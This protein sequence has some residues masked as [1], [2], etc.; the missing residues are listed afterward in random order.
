MHTNT[1]FC[2]E[3]P[4]NKM[5]HFFFF[6][7]LAE[8]T[9][10]ITTSLRVT[11][12]RS[13][14]LTSFDIISFYIISYSQDL[15]YIMHRVRRQDHLTHS[16]AH[17]LKREWV[18]A[19]TSATVKKKNEAPCIIPCIICH[20]KPV[21]ARERCSTCYKAWD[22]ET[23]KREKA[24]EDLDFEAI[25][26]ATRSLAKQKKL[27]KIIHT[28]L[29]QV[30]DGVDVLAPADR[31]AFKALLKPYFDQLATGLVPEPEEEDEDGLDIPDYV[32]SPEADPWEDDALPT[33][34]L[35]KVENVQ[36]NPVPVKT[37]AGQLDNT[38]N[39]QSSPATPVESEEETY[40]FSALMPAQE[41]YLRICGDWLVW[42]H[43]VA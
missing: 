25:E 28:I 43:G 33:G 34:Q 19:R 11:Y 5:Q 35:D 14:L 26:E 15:T 24:G 8:V 10:N 22:R 40:L 18:P 12:L 27:R 37:E 20:D 41:R 38:A 42:P 29:D 21:W 39:V 4:P 32:Q 2:A 31:K 30:E 7:Q 23:K 1:V 16:G 9:G 3:M 13:C 6:R 36:S 17:R